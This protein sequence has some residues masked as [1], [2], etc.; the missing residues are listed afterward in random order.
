MAN[1]PTETA[2]PGAAGSRPAAVRGTLQDRPVPRLLH[3][4]FRKQLTGSLTVIDDSGDESRLFLRDGAPVH[5]E[6]PNDIDRLDQVLIEA[7]LLPPDVIRGFSATLPPGRRLGETLIERGLITAGALANVLKLQ[8]RRKLLRLFFPRKGEFAVYVEAHPYGNGGEFGEMRVDP[9]CLIY[10]GIRTAYDESR[11][12]AELAPLKSHR[13][14]LLSTLSESLL[15]AMGFQPQDLTLRALG[16][17]ALAISELPVTGAKRI[18]SFSVVLALL[19]TDLLDAV[20]VLTPAEAPSPSA[21]KPAPAAPP[22]AAWVTTRLPDPPRQG[23]TGTYPVVGSELGSRPPAAATSTPDAPMRRQT[24]TYSAITGI[25]APARRQTTGTFPAVLGSPGL[26][27][28]GKAS[29][30]TTSYATLASQISDLAEK[31]SVITHY[32]LLGIPE[33]ASLAEIGS[34]YLRL[35]RLYHPDRLSGQG[36]AH[37]NDK[38]ARI[39]AQLNEA[40]SVLADPRRR[41]EYLAALARPAQTASLESGQSILAAERSFQTGEVLLR[42]GDFLRAAESFAD[43]MRGNPL[44]PFYKVYWA[45]A[46][47]DNPGPHKDRLVRETLKIIEDTM[48]ER[49]RFPIGLY[50]IGLLHKHLGDLQ[51]AA[52]AFRASINQDKKMLEAERELRVIELRRTRATAAQPIAEKPAAATAARKDSKILKR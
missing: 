34:S 17:R 14:R 23:A 25:P 51:S 39:V 27:D 20:E 24:G 31:L 46:R 18:D 4:L 48:K 1:D 44:E 19:Y 50:W 52:D 21:L 5:I 38:A 12:E 16:D 36:L 45:W 2:A 6:R 29:T 22:A 35:V 26:A 42:K 47:W 41:S 43:A 30:G 32:Q 10:P 15:E 49:P 33:N 9:R 13:F 28:T 11:L 8:M 7:G 37:L 3:E 40:Q